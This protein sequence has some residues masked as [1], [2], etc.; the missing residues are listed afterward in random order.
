MMLAEVLVIIAGAF[1]CISAISAYLYRNRYIGG[2]TAKEWKFLY[3]GLGAT[4]V[5]LV[6]RG[7]FWIM[8]SSMLYPV[9]DLGLFAGSGVLAFSCFVFWNRFRL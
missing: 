8:E 5:S 9:A 3:Y 6:L 4:G 2:R 1:F 7:I